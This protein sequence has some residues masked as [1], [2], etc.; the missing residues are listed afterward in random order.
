[1]E[2]NEYQETHVHH[3]PDETLV[4]HVLHGNTCFFDELVRRY[5]RLLFQLASRLLQD[6]EQALDVIQEVFLT[7]Y[8][9]LPKL[10][11]DTPLKNWLF[12]VTR[13]RCID[14]LRR[15]HCV[16]RFS[17]LEMGDEENDIPAH[18]ALPAHDPLPEEVA[19]YHELL[20]LLDR[21]L[22]MLPGMYRSI[23]FLRFTAGMSFPQIGQVL[24]IPAN[25]AKAYFRRARLEVYP[26]LQR[27]L[28]EN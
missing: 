1:M 3:L 19:E 15:R 14:V 25:S 22:E 7:L 20:D 6:Q 27:W 13:H 28:A 12:E 2:R 24:G 21:S 10:H 8:L 16:Q 9:Y 4:Q 17:E 5:D 11:T 23:V 18:L 26:S